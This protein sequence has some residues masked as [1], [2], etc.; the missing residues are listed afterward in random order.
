[1]NYRLQFGEILGLRARTDLCGGRLETAVPTAIKC[2]GSVVNISG[3]TVQSGLQAHSGSVVNISGE[4]SVTAFRFDALAGSV[5]NISGGNVAGG[6]FD[7]FS[8][9]VVNIS[10]GSVG[11]NFEAQNGSEVNISGGTVDLDGFIGGVG[12]SVNFQGREF[13]INGTL[14]SDLQLDQPF[15]ITDREVTFSGVLADG[16]P[17][18]F[19]LDTFAYPNFG[20]FSANATLTVT[21]VEPVVLLGDANQDREV[22]FLDISPFISVLSSGEFQAEAD[23]NEDG[24]VDFLDI[25]PF[26]VI[27]AGS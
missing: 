6:G 9:S 16:E 10:G 20:S 2:F 12:S 5:V 24:E 15:T 13:S 14:L 27:L 4:A 26:I 17:F 25:A 8:G 19:F 21:L 23:C 3:G 11:S 22:N 18:S 7:A 1:M